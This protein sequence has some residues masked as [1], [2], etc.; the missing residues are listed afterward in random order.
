MK[1]PVLIHHYLEH[2]ELNQN[3]SFLSFLNTHYQKEINH[4]D[5]R[6]GDHQRLPFKTSDCHSTH[7]PVIVPQ[8]EFGFSIP[9][10]IE[11]NTMKVYP[12]EEHHSFAHIE[13]IWQPPR[14]G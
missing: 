9:T 3:E 13:T 11:F 12:T 5:D 1:F 6:H 7:I 10:A 2:V 4:P 8:P 14:L